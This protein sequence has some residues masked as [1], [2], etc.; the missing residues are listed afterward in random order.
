M[1]KEQFIYYGFLELTKKE[2]PHY[3]LLI[4]I[5][6]DKLKW[7]VKAAPKLWQKQI[8]SGQCYIQQLNNFTNTEN[9]F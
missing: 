6:P 7:F 8:A 5:T 2:D 1:V 3:H 4:Y 9:I